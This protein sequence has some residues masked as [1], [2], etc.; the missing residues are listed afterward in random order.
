MHEVISSLEARIATLER[1]NRRGRL[2]TTMLGAFLGV[3]VLTGQAPTSPTLIGDVNGAHIALAP[4]GITIYG[5]T[6]TQVAVD[7][8]AYDYG[9][10]IKMYDVAGKQRSYEGVFSDNGSGFEALDKGATYRT[11][12]GVQ[13]DGGAGLEVYD[14]RG[15]GRMSVAIGANDKTSIVEKSTTGADVVRETGDDTGGFLRVGDGTQITRAY[16]GVYTDGAS[17]VAAYD[18]AGK[19]TWSSPGQASAK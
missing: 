11:F 2:V 4:T 1:A 15:K 6:G 14:A 17:G 13:P 8:R 18:K 3:A 19:V 12:S 10:G 7:I 5:R 16:I 9:G